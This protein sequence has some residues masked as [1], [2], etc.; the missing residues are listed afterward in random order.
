[1]TKS[2]R[3]DKTCG[4]SA[5]QADDIYNSLISMV[6]VPYEK[7]YRVTLVDPLAGGR[8]VRDTD[9]EIFGR[10]SMVPRQYGWGK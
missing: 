5:R 3:I 7:Y 9:H 6:T 1:M 2:G 4:L 10:Q 8:I